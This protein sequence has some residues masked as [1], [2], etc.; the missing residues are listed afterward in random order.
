MLILNHPSRNVMHRLFLILIAVVFT[1]AAAFAQELTPWATYRGNNARTANTDNKPGPTAP[2]VLWSWKTKENFLASPTPAGQRLLISGLGAFNVGTF[3]CLDAGPK[4]KP[5]VNWSKSTPYLTLP[6]VSSPSI[7]GDR[8]IFGDGMHQTDGANLHCVDLATGASIWQLPVPGTLVHL[9]G[10]PTIVGG[11]VYIGGGAAGALCVDLDKMTLEGKVMD[12]ASVKKTLAARWKDLLAQ[13]EIEK[14]TNPDFAI[15][16]TEDKLPRP[17]PVRQ[18]QQGKDKWHVDAPIAVAGNNV[19]VASAFLDKEKVGD[20]A[21]YCLDGNTGDVRW[22]A[23]LKLNPWGGPSIIG[24]QVI[25][26][27][28]SIGYYPNAIKGA[29]GFIA[30]Y[31]LKKGKA[32]LWIKD[33]PAGVVS[34]AALAD[35]AAVVT[36]TDGK[37]R[38]FDLATGER[39]WVREGKIPY[40]APPAIAA[41]VVYTGDWNGTLH[42]LDLKTGAPRWSLD[43]GSDPSVMSPGMVYGGPIVHEGRVYL[44]TCNLEGPFARQPTVVVCVG[45]K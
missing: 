10:S 45:E 14:K 39:R 44:A 21:L 16:P 40:F 11:K 8:V 2:K 15:P 28:S 6:S 30:A 38:A 3:F 36:A 9:E 20:R 32:P 35:G 13:Y 17:A 23:D 22:R 25:V 24:D 19:L 37:V 31:D 33:I 5:S 26:T 41:G 34:C 12:A 42:A 4:A 1:Q 7:V 43:L 29:K 27:G 18:W